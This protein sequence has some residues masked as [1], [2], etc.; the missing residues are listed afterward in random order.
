MVAPSPA[1][2]YVL[3]RIIPVASLPDDDWPA[4]LTLPSEEIPLRLRDPVKGGLC[5]SMVLRDSGQAL[6]ARAAMLWTAELCSVFNDGTRD[7][8]NSGATLAGIAPFK[9]V[10]A[11]DA[12]HARYAIRVVATSGIPVAVS[13]VELW[14]K[15]I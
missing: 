6:V 7:V 15:G 12:D 9:I 2:D 14:V 3:Y 5:Y 11:D 13:T 10:V 4:D 1:I 8:A